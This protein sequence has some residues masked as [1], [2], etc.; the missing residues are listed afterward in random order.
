MSIHVVARD[1]VRHVKRRKRRR[2]DRRSNVR[3][4]AAAQSGN[5]IGLPAAH[6]LAQW[7]GHIEPAF[8][9]S[10]WELV[11]ITHDETL[12]DVERSSAAVSSA[13]KRVQKQSPN[14]VVVTVPH[15]LDERAG[16]DRPASCR[17]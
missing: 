13:V 14:G 3:G 5:T 16:C 8:A 2:N 7:S 15:Y 9:S 12:W 11:T 4:K 6:N 10:K 1:T 17:Q